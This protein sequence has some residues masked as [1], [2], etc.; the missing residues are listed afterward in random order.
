MINPRP[1]PSPPW[2]QP[3][4]PDS[5]R[6]NKQM[7]SLACAI[8]YLWLLWLLLC[9]I[10]TGDPGTLLNSPS[11]RRTLSCGNSTPQGPYECACVSFRT[12]VQLPSAAIPSRCPEPLM[13]G[14][15]DLASFLS[16]GLFCLRS[17]PTVP[18]LSMDSP[19][20]STDNNIYH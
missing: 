6:E 7:C 12:H 15:N 16:S 4:F 9:V 5:R 11:P 10:K 17:C 18:L 19:T 13:L 8:R 14:I 3:D 1:S 2:S 20:G